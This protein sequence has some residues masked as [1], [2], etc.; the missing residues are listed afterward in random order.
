MDWTCH[1]NAGVGSRLDFGPLLSSTSCAR[2]TSIQLC[3]ARKLKF[4]G[5]WHDMN[6]K[7]RQPKLKLL[8]HGSLIIRWLEM[9]HPRNESTT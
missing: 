7:R 9:G 2:C 8:G 4:N 3:G 6:N 1:T 5:T